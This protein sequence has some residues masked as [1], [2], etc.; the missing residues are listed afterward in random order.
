MSHIC[1]ELQMKGWFSHYET[2][3]DFMVQMPRCHI[4][5][6]II[7]SFCVETSTVTS[8]ITTKF[9]LLTKVQTGYKSVKKHIIAIC[10]WLLKSE[11]QSID[12]SC[13]SHHFK[14]TTSLKRKC[15]QFLTLSDDTLSLHSTNT[16]PFH[17]KWSVEC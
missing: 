3:H 8:Y 7:W 13:A 16:M 10:L 9:H 14:G 6:S 12:A 15:A 5:F 17:M 2:Q 4:Q 1:F 11:P